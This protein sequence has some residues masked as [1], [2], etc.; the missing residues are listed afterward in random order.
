MRHFKKYYNLDTDNDKIIDEYNI[1]GIIDEIVGSIENMFMIILRKIKNIHPDYS[2]ELT[3]D[4]KIEIIEIIFDFF[5]HLGIE[6][7]EEHS[8]NKCFNQ[9]SKIH[10]KIIYTC[11][12]RLLI[13][14]DKYTESQ[15]L[16][17]HYILLSSDKIEKMIE[18]IKMKK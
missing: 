9:S 11:L 7:A 2:I 13:K 15:L 3:K 1:G 10:F 18:D 8:V 14:N 5:I 4:F 12:K 16:V 6:I 17:L